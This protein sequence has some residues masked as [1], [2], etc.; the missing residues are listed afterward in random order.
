MIS[1]ALKDFS[2]GRLN[3]DNY[4]DLGGGIQNTLI[5]NSEFVEK[6]LNI[7]DISSPAL[8]TVGLGLSQDC[9]L[10]MYTNPVELLSTLMVSSITNDSDIN[11]LSYFTKLKSEISD[12]DIDLDSVNSLQIDLSNSSSVAID[13]VIRDNEETINRLVEVL[14]S[15]ITKVSRI[16]LSSI[17]D[18]NIVRFFLKIASINTL[19]V[20]SVHSV[21]NCNTNAL[22]IFPI[23]SNSKFGED[24][25]DLDLQTLS[26]KISKCDCSDFLDCDVLIGSN[27]GTIRYSIS[28]LE[29][30]YKS[31]K[32]VIQNV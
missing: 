25:K 3:L 16:N 31:I 7:L 15:L 11:L 30:T 5:T 26:E 27:E 12:I 9:N 21:I 32:E 13:W 20:D 14:S 24:L 6:G 23:K 22:G 19:S 8:F 29:L 17:Q 2:K 1:R 10:E 28:L 18:P 4:F